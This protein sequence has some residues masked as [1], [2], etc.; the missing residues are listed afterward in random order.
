M[1]GADSDAVLIEEAADVIGMVFTQIEGDHPGAM[2]RAID[3]QRRLWL[4][5]FSA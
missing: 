5:A 1:A 2:G 3:F 4:S